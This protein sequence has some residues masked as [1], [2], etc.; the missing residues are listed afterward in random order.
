MTQCLTHA[1]YDDWVNGQTA[2]RVWN[3]SNAHYR[4]YVLRI[5]NE[6][7]RFALYLAHVKYKKGASQ[8]LLYDQQCF[9]KGTRIIEQQADRTPGP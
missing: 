8:P 7:T 9:A 6:A 3:G 4:H 5:R 2:A 1:K